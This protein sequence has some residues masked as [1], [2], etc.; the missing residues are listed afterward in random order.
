MADQVAARAAALRRERDTTASGEPARS[1][2]ASL[3]APTA[4]TPHPARN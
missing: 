1:A 2:A 3:A 4:H